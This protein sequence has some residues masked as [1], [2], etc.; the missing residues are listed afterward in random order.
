LN[1]IE[2]VHNPEVISNNLSANPL[3]AGLVPE[4]TKIK[5][6]IHDLLLQYRLNND[7]EDEMVSNVP[8][9]NLKNEK[10]ESVNSRMIASS[11]PY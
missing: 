1:R 4:P 10:S 11:I 3:K 8:Q 5:E 7:N 2:Y 9:K 6:R